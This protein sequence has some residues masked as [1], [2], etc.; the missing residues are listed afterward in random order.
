[1]VLDLT[2]RSPTAPGKP[3]DINCS[4]G[5]VDV[6]PPFKPRQVAK[7]TTIT[8][9][10]TP[11]IPL[12]I[13]QVPL[14]AL[15]DTGASKSIIHERLFNKLP[16]RGQ[17]VCSQ[18]EF[19]LYDV[20]EK[21]LHTLGRVTLPVRY[22]ES[23]LRQEFIITNGVS[24]DCILGWDAIQK[25]GFRLDGE[26]KSIYLARD[27]QGPLAISK[28]PDMVI[29]TVKKTTLSRQTS[30]VIAAQVTG[31]FPYVPP[32]SAFMFTP[33]EDL[34]AG[35][36]IEEFIGNVSGD[37]T[38]FLGLAGYY[39]KFIQNFGSLAQPLTRLT[40]KDLIK[41]P[42]TWGN[43]EQ[44]AFEKLINSLVTPPVLA[45][46]NFNEKFL[47]F[48]DACDYDGQEHPLAYFS[49]QLRKAEMKY[50]TTEKEA[51]AV[52]EAI[53]HFRHYLLDKPFEIISDHR[54][55]Q[56]LRNQKDNNGRLG[57]WAILL[58]ATNYE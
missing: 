15:F 7:L 41:K 3:I 6:K 45:Y 11:R 21:K 42:F 46:P 19:D 5:S 13:F 28:V 4:F 24:E 20:G 22:G 52:I 8:N 30:M 54:P 26:A 25:H 37:G 48:T 14:Q 40:H 58:A 23:L 29:T 35:I 57:R 34:P 33:V 1:M 55:L 39:R 38:S 9:E 17:V 36:Y 18:L 44:V 27:E 47:L 53:K 31:S 16:P 12:K 49:R 32:F 43:E 10:S 51:L 2:K 56:W 50:S